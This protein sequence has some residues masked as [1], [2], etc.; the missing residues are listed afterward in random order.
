MS[1]FPFPSHLLTLLFLFCFTSL[2]PSS[3]SCPTFFIIHLTRGIYV[4][5]SAGTFPLPHPPPEYFPL[6]LAAIFVFIVVCPLDIFYKYGTSPR[7][8][9]SFIPVFLFIITKF[10]QGKVAIGFS[11]HWDELLLLLSGMFYFIYFLFFFYFL[12][13]LSLL[14]TFLAKIYFTFIDINLP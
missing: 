10:I 11:V 2:P 14:H 5:T 1:C 7:F 8:L 12:F 9:P 4:W 6:I 3:C 13:S